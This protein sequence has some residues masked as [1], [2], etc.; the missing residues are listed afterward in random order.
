MRNNLSARPAARAHEGWE[1]DERREHGRRRERDGRGEHD[2]RRERGMLLWIEGPL[3]QVVYRPAEA[4][5]LLVGGGTG[6]APIKS[7]LRHVIEN[8]LPRRMSLYWGVRSE[9]DLYAHE[10]LEELIRR[11][12]ALRYQAVLS[13]PC[14]AWAGRRGLVHEAV[15]QDF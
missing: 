4:P 10:Q 12:P 15:L 1:D 2:G 11:A 3:V 5:M 8:D 6:L 14:A 7:I 13:E 9:R